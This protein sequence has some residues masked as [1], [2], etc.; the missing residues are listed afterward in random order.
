MQR[1]F[2]K[3]AYSG[4]PFNGWQIQ[5]N[6]P[7]V[8]EELEKAL[9]TVLRQKINVVGCGRTDTGVHASEFF[10]HFETDL[11]FDVSKLPFKLNC[12]IPFEIAIYD[13]WK[14]SADFHARFTATSRTYHYFIN[15]VKDPF[16]FNKSWYLHQDLDLDKMNE[17]CQ[18]LL[19]EQDFTS[20]SKLHTQTRTNICTVTEAKWVQVGHQ[21]RFTVTANRFLHNMVRAIVGTSVNVG[22]GKITPKDFNEI[23]AAK[24]R[25]K[26]G[27]SVPAH[28]LFL[29]GIGYP[30]V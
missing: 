6:A 10:A 9:F 17:A 18:Y 22:K 27:A 13:I 8:Q 24:S 23:I 19:G 7:T 21:I 12:I 16:N 28:G 11:D 25:Q 15:Q 29:V 3:L 5:P 30:D 26:A 20:F 14:V 4:S 2:I 1:Y